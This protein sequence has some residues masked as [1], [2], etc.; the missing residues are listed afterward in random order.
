LSYSPMRFLIRRTINY[1]RIG[2]YVKLV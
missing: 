2:V 1:S